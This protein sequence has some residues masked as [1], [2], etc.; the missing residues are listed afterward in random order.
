MSCWI[1]RLIRSCG[2]WEIIRAMLFDTEHDTC[3]GWRGRKWLGAA[4]A[5]AAGPFFDRETW[6]PAKKKRHT[7]WMVGSLDLHAA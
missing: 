4:D 7:W 2:R 6:K 5:L 1:G 3:Q